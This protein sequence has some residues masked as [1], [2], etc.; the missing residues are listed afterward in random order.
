MHD[1][2]ARDFMHPS[3]MVNDDVA[4]PQ[5]DG[6]DLDHLLSPLIIGANPSVGVDDDHAEPFVAVVSNCWC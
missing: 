5:V 3:R 4:G 6:V 1:E 2:N